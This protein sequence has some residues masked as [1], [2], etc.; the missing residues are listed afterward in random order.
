MDGRNIEG[1]PEKQAIFPVAGPRV[2]CDKHPSR[3][4]GRNAAPTNGRAGT[5][6]GWV[7]QLVEQ[8]TENPRVPGSIPGPATIPNQLILSHL[9][10]A[11]QPV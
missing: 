7:A 11:I 2:Q 1:L 9:H 6:K 3:A 5:H 4:T 10:K 8:R